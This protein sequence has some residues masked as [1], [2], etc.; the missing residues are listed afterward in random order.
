[1]KRRIVNILLAACLTAGM[2]VGSLPTA[3]LEVARFP[4]EGSNLLLPVR[5]RV[6]TVS[7]R[8]YIFPGLVMIGQT[9]RL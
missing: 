3:G 7:R 8:K 1:M 4:P 6:C 5:P 9:D 2:A